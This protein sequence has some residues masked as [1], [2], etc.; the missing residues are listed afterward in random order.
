MLGRLDDLVQ[1]PGC[2]CSFDLQQRLPQLLHSCHTV[3]ASCIDVLTAD[4]SSN[5]IICPVCEE[6]VDEVGATPLNTLVHDVL[7]TMYTEEGAARWA[8]VEERTEAPVG[9]NQP[10]DYA[11]VSAMQEQLAQVQVQMRALTHA[12]QALQHPAPQPALALAQPP[13]P[14][15][16]KR[17]NFVARLEPQPPAVETCLHRMIQM[18]I[19][20]SIINPGP[21]T[22]DREMQQAMTWP[23]AP[24]S[25]R[26]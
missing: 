20:R 18:V 24:S 22:S 7:E 10:S 1:C 17:P 11:V 19:Q 14:T 2:T 12:I 16:P 25:C 13:L 8:L 26:G 5:P 4:A 6:E 9:S 21:Y 23:T 3:C 15:Q